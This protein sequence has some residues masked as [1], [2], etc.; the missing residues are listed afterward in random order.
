V[1]GRGGGA[2][3]EAGMG[4]G[5]AGA[6]VSAESAAAEASGGAETRRGEVGAA[7]NRGRGDGKTEELKTLLSDVMGRGLESDPALRWVG[8]GGK[9]AEGGREECREGGGA[10]ER[11]RGCARERERERGTDTSEA[12]LLQVLR[13][14]PSCVCVCLCVCMCL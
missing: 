4:H 10:S 9:E 14:P 11:G 8:E 1:G 2:L 12:R 3:R 6:Q 5:N 13:M 7:E